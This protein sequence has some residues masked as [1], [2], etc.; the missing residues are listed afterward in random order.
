M[1]DILEIVPN[2]IYEQSKILSCFDWTNVINKWV[3]LLF[4]L[5]FILHVVH[6]WPWNQLYWFISFGDYLI[7]LSVSW[8]DS[9]QLARHQ[10]MLL[11]VHS[12]WIFPKH[13]CVEEHQLQQSTVCEQLGATFRVK[14]LQKFLLTQLVR[15]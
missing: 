8:L 11:K 15:S 14:M 6:L 12:S 2:F 13:W 3:F 9:Y 5:L 10:N 4:L 7:K 1:F